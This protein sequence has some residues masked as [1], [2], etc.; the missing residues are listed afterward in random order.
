MGDRKSKVVEQL[1]EEM[2]ND[3]WHVKLKR[4][5]NLKVWTYK[6]LSRKYWDKTYKHYIFKSKEQK[7]EEAKQ[8]YR[9]IESAIIRWNIHGKR[10]A[11]S[12]TRQILKIIEK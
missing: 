5:W 4:W 1:L 3:P 10:T 11:G 9:D 12:L 6:C 2:K 8:L 7:Q